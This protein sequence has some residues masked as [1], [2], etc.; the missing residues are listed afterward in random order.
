MDITDIKRIIIGYHEQFHDN[1]FDNLRRTKS[2]RNKLPKLTQESI[3]ISECM[4][5]KF[6]VYN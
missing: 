3:E 4:H 2:G 6:L 5:F 1:K